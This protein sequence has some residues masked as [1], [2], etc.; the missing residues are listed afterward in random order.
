MEALVREVAEQIRPGV[1]CLDA[2]LLP[3]AAVCFSFQP[4][5]F[6]DGAADSGSMRWI[7][8]TRQIDGR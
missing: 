6:G 5:L 8:Q 1:S 7:V 3:G 4:A 2:N